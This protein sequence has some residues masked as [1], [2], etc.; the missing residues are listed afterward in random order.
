MS[1]DHWHHAPSF[2]NVGSNDYALF[3]FVILNAVSWGIG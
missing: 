1:F 3:Q 2:G